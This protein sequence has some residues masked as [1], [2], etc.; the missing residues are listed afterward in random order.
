MQASFEL[1]TLSSF[2]QAS[3]N[4]DGWIVGGVLSSAAWF[5]LIRSNLA[6]ICS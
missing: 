5:A 4:D 6:Q 3:D 2:D 1:T